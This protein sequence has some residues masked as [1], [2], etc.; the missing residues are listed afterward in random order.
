MVLPLGTP[1]DGLSSI[2]MVVYNIFHTHHPIKLFPDGWHLVCLQ[3]QSD[4]AI[5]NDPLSIPWTPPPL[6]KVLSGIF[7]LLQH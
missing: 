7:R 4:P 6:F 1:C 2:F 5:E 3:E